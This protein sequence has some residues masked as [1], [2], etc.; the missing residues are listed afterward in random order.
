M[1]R[2][3]SRLSNDNTGVRREGTTAEERCGRPG[4]SVYRRA[5][6]CSHEIPTLT[7]GIQKN[8]PGRQ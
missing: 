4:L 6:A 5:F 8:K 3:G 2:K 1:A 7:G